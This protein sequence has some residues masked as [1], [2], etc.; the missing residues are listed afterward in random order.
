MHYLHWLTP[1][2]LEIFGQQSSMAVMLCFACAQKAYLIHLIRL[3]HIGDIPVI[4]KID[5]LRLV[6]V[7]AYLII[8]ERL[9]D[10]IGG[11]ELLAVFVINAANFF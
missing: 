11:G 8:L 5:I 6:F 7:P 9:Q 10:V 4:N 3:Q 2:S 1:F